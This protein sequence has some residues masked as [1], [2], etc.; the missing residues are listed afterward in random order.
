MWTLW[1]DGGLTY[2]ALEESGLLLSLGAGEEADNG[3]HA[4][5]GD[6]F[7]GLRLRG[8]WVSYARLIG[9]CRERYCLRTMVLGPPTSRMCCTPRPPGVSFFASSPQ[10]ETSL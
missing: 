5:E 6:G 4:V 9:T 7:E 2:E 10:L 3:D 8:R 1:E